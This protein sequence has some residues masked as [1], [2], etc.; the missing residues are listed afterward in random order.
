MFTRVYRS[1]FRRGFLTSGIAC[2]KKPTLRLRTLPTLTN[3]LR[4]RRNGAAGEP[5]TPPKSSIPTPPAKTV[6]L[7][8]FDK[9]RQPG[10]FVLA[11]TVP[12]ETLGGQVPLATL[13]GL[14]NVWHTDRVG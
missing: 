5:R 3:A 10:A 8:T 13:V 12:D 7:S 6:S 9:P 14:G 2:I 11:F 1:R 4:T